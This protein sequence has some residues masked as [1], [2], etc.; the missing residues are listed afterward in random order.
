MTMENKLK[1]IELEIGLKK[2]NQEQQASL[3]V[4]VADDEPGIREIHEEFLK[5]W[6][7]KVKTV[8]DGEALF[9][10]LYKNGKEYDLVITDKTMSSRYENEEIRIKK[11]GIEALKKLRKI[12]GL[13]NI[14]VIVVTGDDDPNSKDSLKNTI[15]SLGAY[16]LKKPNYLSDLEK[17]VKRIAI[18]KAAAEKLKIKKPEIETTE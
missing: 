14:P 3:N 6:G 4:L 9:E 15:E 1:Q 17:I 13:E 11:D 10:E 12:E 5:A 7:H 8:P 16:Y 2:E 18:E